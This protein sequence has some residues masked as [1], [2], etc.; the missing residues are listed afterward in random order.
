MEQCQEVPRLNGGPKSFFIS[1][2]LTGN[3][4]ENPQSARG[5]AQCK[6]SL[7][8]N[9]ISYIGLTNNDLL[10]QLT[11]NNNSP[12]TRQFLRDK[13]LLKKKELAS[14]NAH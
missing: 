9:M 5:P 7:D 3:C 2:I 13:M 4:S 11:F 1:P 14:K 12:P 10:Y 8:K 6:S